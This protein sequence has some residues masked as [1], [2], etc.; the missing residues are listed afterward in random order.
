[1]KV[2]YERVFEASPSPMAVLTP[3][4]VFLTANT[5]YLRVTGRTRTDL[6]GQNIFDAFPSNPDEPDEPEAHGTEFLRASLERVVATRE[7]DTMAMQR[8]DVSPPDRPGEFEERY[9][10]PINTPILGP[11]GTVQLIVHRVEEV[12]AFVQQLRKPRDAE[13]ERAELEAMEADAYIRSRELQDLNE[14]LRQTHTRER[15]TASALRQ[16]FEQQQRF[17]LDASHDLRNPIAGLL[18]RLEV[19]LSDPGAD[20]KQ[21]LCSLLLDAQRL[22]DIVADLLELARLDTAA[23]VP[24]E[25]VDLGRLVVDELEGRVLAVPVTVQFDTQVVVHV[26]RIRLCR[27]LGNLLANAERHATSLIQIIIS[28]D[29]PYAVM[30]VIDDG[31]GIPPAHRERVFERLY[32]LDDAR[33]QDPGGTGLGLPIAREIARAYGGHLH[34]ADH[35]TGARL[36][37]RLPLAASLR[38]G[39]PRR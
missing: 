10:S 27:V 7:R 15:E 24:A 38:P 20:P 31:P 25:P 13:S 29:P 35:P 14:R 18:T 23:T 30:E 11:D 3:D 17:V 1:M 37:L 2:D 39:R 5:A 33:R 22:N 26:S 28:T 34:C 21:I 9:W 16:A 36:V 32:R 4:F 12:T 8:Y 19:A 6:V